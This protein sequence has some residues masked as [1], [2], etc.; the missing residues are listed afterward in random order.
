MQKK[1]PMTS[2]ILT[3]LFGPFGVFYSS[4]VAAIGIFV[5]TLYLGLGVEFL[6]EV[7]SMIGLDGFLGIYIGYKGGQAIAITIYILSI[8]IGFISVEVYNSKID[9]L[10]RMIQDKAYD[11]ARRIRSNNNS[12]S[13]PIL[14]KIRTN[15]FSHS[16]FS[17]SKINNDENEIA[18]NNDDKT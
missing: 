14:N 1:S 12:S 15:G 18:E 5:L 16:F 8:I 17:N 10:E 3:L 13:T 7:L 6:M 11:I 2:F 9:T 4:S